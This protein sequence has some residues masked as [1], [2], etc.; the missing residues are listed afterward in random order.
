MVISPP[1]KDTARHFVQCPFLF[2]LNQPSGKPFQPLHLYL[3][4][5]QLAQRLLGGL[6]LKVSVCRP[7]RGFQFR[8]VGAADGS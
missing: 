4:A 8:V 6:L 2:I 5:A 1:K 3:C 7:Q